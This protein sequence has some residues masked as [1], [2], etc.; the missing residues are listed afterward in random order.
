MCR[1]KYLT[2]ESGSVFCMHLI[3]YH[4]STAPSRQ[5][6]SHHQK[7]GL[8]SWYY[9]IFLNSRPTHV[10]PFW[11]AL[12]YRTSWWCD[13]FDG[14][15]DPPSCME[16][17]ANTLV[18]ARRYDRGFF[19]ARAHTPH[20]ANFGTTHAGIRAWICESLLVTTR[21]GYLGNTPGW[22]RNQICWRG[23]SPTR[24]KYCY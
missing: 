7:F 1:G 12:V 22:T 10:C 18:D 19:C 21:V 14:V 16:M 9:R 17:M 13:W 6:P 2:M 5:T 4:V 23:K 15:F 8:C 20:R 24:I 3:I 11:I